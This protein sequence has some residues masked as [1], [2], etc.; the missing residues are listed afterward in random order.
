MSMVRLHQHLH[1]EGEME[2]QGLTSLLCS[3]KTLLRGARSE[4][5]LT[6]LKVSIST[7]CKRS[8]LADPDLCTMAG[9]A[10]QKC[11]KIRREMCQNKQDKSAR[12]NLDRT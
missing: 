2:V 7:D 1:R 8:S 3:A 12:R 11:A 10:K 4:T 9:P 6:L 5:V